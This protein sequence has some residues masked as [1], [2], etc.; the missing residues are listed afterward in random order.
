MGPVTRGPASLQ[1]WTGHD[2]GYW[3]LRLMVT[4]AALDRLRQA[5]RQFPDGFL[6]LFPCVDAVPLDGPGHGIDVL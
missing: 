4:G 2:A 6:P 5:V 1:A 3:S